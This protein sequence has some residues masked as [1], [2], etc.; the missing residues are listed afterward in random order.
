VTA[1]SFT[2]N[3]CAWALN[4]KKKMVVAIVKPFI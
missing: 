4:T 3:T 1:C 2:D